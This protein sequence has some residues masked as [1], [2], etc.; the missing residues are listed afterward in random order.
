MKRS[1]KRP[2]STKAAIE[3]LKQLLSLD[4]PLPE[5]TRRFQAAYIKKQIARARGSITEAAERLGLHRANL[6]RKMQQ[7][8]ITGR[9]G[10]TKTGAPRKKAA[11]KKTLTSNPYRKMR[12]KG[13]A[14]LRVVRSPPSSF[15]LR[16][17]RESDDLANQYCDTSQLASGCRRRAQG[18]MS[19][20]VHSRLAGSAH[21]RS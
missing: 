12:K 13:P 15:R 21:R 9:E 18:F 10:E 17:A 16:A 4:L 5:A 3:D 6:Y 19:T 11:K 8:G 7:L 2:K 14:H 20:N 1:V